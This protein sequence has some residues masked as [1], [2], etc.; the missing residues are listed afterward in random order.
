[1]ENY[2]STLGFRYFEFLFIY[3]RI[4]N[5][6][7]IRIFGIFV[8]SLIIIIQSQLKS[9]WSYCVLLCFC[10]RTFFVL[11]FIGLSL[12]FSVF[13]HQAYL[14]SLAFIIGCISIFIIFVIFLK[15][16]VDFDPCGWLQKCC[17]LVIKLCLRESANFSEKTL[18]AHFYSLYGIPT[19][20]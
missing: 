4:W 7:R 1:M 14:P 3:E 13:W 12:F 16:I 18:W 10:L 6:I 5:Q 19:L 8:L 11:C 2:F 15:T 20:S 17:F 9:L